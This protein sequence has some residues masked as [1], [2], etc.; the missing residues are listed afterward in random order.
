MSIRWDGAK[1]SEH[2]SD[3][4]K[5]HSSLIF[6][7]VESCILARLAL[8]SKILGRGEMLT[9]HVIQPINTR[10]LERISEVL[11]KTSI[12]SP[13]LLKT[14]ELHGRNSLFAW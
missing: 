11:P 14:P 13:R 2:V 5:I 4:L 3:F 8:A 1:T 10:I 9:P 12:I 6:G 7:D